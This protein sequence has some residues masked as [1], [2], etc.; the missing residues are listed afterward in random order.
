MIG[1]MASIL[2]AVTLRNPMFL[3]IIPAYALRLR[4][5]NAALIGFYAYTIALAATLPS[6][7]IYEGAGLKV[8]VITGSSILLALDEVLRGIEVEKE[9]LA[10]SGVLTAS[11][12]NDYT[13]IIIL[14]GVTLYTLH[15]NFGKALAYLVGWL[16]G[17]VL[18]LYTGR[19][20][21]SDPAAQALVILGVGLIFLLLAERK[22][23]EFLEVALREK[24]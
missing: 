22:E 7:S 10:V 23:A 8:A 12:L 9:T 21:L 3:L 6:T 1:L 19:E 24:D 11:A 17:S 13:F 4:S 14:V 5:R 20:R 16:V 2:A 15:R 18:L